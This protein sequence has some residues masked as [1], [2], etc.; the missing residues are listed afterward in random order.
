MSDPVSVTLSART[1]RRLVQNASTTASPDDGRPMLTCARIVVTEKDLTIQST[2]SYRLLHQVFA[3]PDDPE[4]GSFC[5]RVGQLLEW[6]RLCDPLLPAILKGNEDRVA[7]TCG[8]LTF[9]GP[10]ASAE[11]FPDLSK[12]IT[13]PDNPVFERAAFNGP[14]LA[15]L[16]EIDPPSGDTLQ[17]WM[18]EQLHHGE[19]AV[20][21]RSDHDSWS[22][23]FAIMPVRTS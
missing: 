19:A 22:A 10:A 8:E 9:S 12:F 20:F 14:Y 5:V 23:V 21:T 15:A 18:C 2:D 11:G 17:P 16:T 4:P 3:R 1:L 13:I 6:T 7:L